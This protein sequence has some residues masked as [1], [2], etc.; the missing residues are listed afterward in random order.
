MNVCLNCGYP[1]VGEVHRVAGFGM[2]YTCSTACCIDLERKWAAAHPEPPASERGPLPYAVV[3]VALDG[4][5]ES[6]APSLRFEWEA[7]NTGRFAVRLRTNG[8]DEASL[9][10]EE[11][12]YCFAEVSLRIEDDPPFSQQELARRCLQ[13]AINARIVRCKS[14]GVLMANLP[15]IELPEPKPGNI[16]EGDD[17]ALFRVAWKD[18]QITTIRS[19][20]RGSTIHVE[21]GGGICNRPLCLSP[22]EAWTDVYELRKRPLYAVI[23]PDCKRLV[24]DHRSLLAEVRFVLSESL[25]GTQGPPS[26]EI[27][28]EEGCTY[29][30][31]VVRLVRGGEGVPPQEAWPTIKMFALTLIAEGYATKHSRTRVR[32]RREAP[33]PSGLPTFVCGRK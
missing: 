20:A 11:H 28:V 6:L 3:P 33:G 31:A 29:G 21:A 12:G 13:A 16:V 7:P 25:E 24:E 4:W 19:T 30:E 9:H 23:C 26:A 27:V 14:G 8:S 32:V 22:S 15:R 2:I 18:P 1:S 17:G 5:Q 10:V